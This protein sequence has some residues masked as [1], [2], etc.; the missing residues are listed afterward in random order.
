MYAYIPTSDFSAA[1]T[2]DFV[3]LYL[4]LYAHFGNSDA[5]QSGFE[6][7]ALVNVAPI[8]E[9]DALFPIIGFFA[10]AFATQRLRR[11]QRAQQEST[12]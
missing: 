9:M 2:S 8:P 7:W 12:M 11:R 10:V 5:S 1:K 6:E 3:Y 4:Y